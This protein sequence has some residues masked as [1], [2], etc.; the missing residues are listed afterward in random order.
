MQE[1]TSGRL[2]VATPVLD[3]P[4]FE[5]TVVLVGLHDTGG[6]FGV[7]LNRPADAHAADL[8]PEWGHLLSPPGRL[9]AGGPVERSSF[10]AIGLMTP[11]EPQHDWW[12]P[13][14]LGL[15]LVDLSV[16][17]EAAEGLHALRVFHGYAGWAATQLEIEIGEEAWFVVDARPDD[18]FTEDP[19]RLWNRVLQRQR[20]ELAIYGTYPSDLRVN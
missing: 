4:N 2:L 6:A 12:T 9:H 1:F 17:A 10:L 16:D 15:G 11:D 20:G 8:L 3:D 7:V 18:V 14:G 5:R 13:I 19:D